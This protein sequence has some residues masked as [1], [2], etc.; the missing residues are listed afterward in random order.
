MVVAPTGFT[1]T[2]PN[3]GNGTNDSDIDPVTGMSQPFSLGSGEVR[4]EFDAGLKGRIDIA[5][6]KRVNRSIVAVGETVEFTIT[7]IN[8]G[9][10]V[11]TGVQITDPVPGGFFNISDVSNGGALNGNT[12]TWS[13][14][15][16]G[17][18][19]SITLTFS[20]V[21][22]GDNESYTNVAQVTAADQEDAD[23][24]PNNDDGDQ[25][26]D[27]EDVAS[28]VVSGCD[29]SVSVNTQ[30]AICTASNGMAQ[31][32]AT[33]GVAPF[34]YDWSTGDVTATVTNLPV[35]TVTVTIT[36]A[37]GC[38][39]TIDVEI[40]QDMSDIDVNV[41]TV[42]ITCGSVDGQAT[43]TA[44]G[45]TAPYTYAWSTGDMT[46]TVI[47]LP[48]GVFT[49]TVTDANGCVETEEVEIRFDDNNL[50]LSVV[51]TQRESCNQ[52]NDGIGEVV[53]TGG[54]QPFTYLWS[55]GFNGP[56]QT[57]LSEGV[58]TVDVI[59]G[60]R[61]TATTTVVIERAAGCGDGMTD[62]GNGTGG[63]NTGGGNNPNAI[64]LELIKRTNIS[65]PRVGDTVVFQLTV[66]NNS[67]NNATGV[68]IED[69]VPS[70]FTIVPG[71]IDNG[72]VMT[73]PNVATWTD[74]DIDAL[75]VIRLSI[76]V[77]VNESGD[78]T[79]VAQITEAD[80]IDIDSTPGN[81]DGDQ[82]EDDE[83][84]AVA[85]P[86]TTDIAITN[87]VS[88]PNPEIG[89]IV[90]YT[91]VVRNEGTVDATGVEVTDYLPVDF[92]ENFT[93]FSGNGLFLRDRIIW[94]DLFIPAGGELTLSF[95]ATV[96]PSAD[97]QVVTNFSEVTEMDQSDVDSE[98][99]NLDRTAGPREDDE[100]I[101]VFNV[102]TSSDLEL[103]KEVDQ[104]Q[105]SPNDEVQFSI[106]VTNNGPD[107][108]F[109]VGVEDI[110]PDGY[111]TIS[112]ISDDGS[113]TR[114]RLFWF[115]DE[116]AV[117]ESV[118]LTFDATVVHFTDRESDYRNVAQIVESFTFDPDSTPDNDDGDQSED[119]EDFEEVQ[120]ILDGGACVT[121]N[122]G[123]FLEG[124]YDVDAGLMTTEL[125]RLGYL[126]GQR[127]STFFGVATPAG[128][129]YNQAPWFYNGSEGAGFNQQG[130]VTNTNGNY[131]STVTDWVLV[132][133]RTD[134]S[135]ASTVCERA[136]LLHN[137][138]S[139]QFV[140]EFDCC[141]LDQSL[142]YYIVIE[143]R[144]HLL[145]MSDVPLP[146]I[147]G[148]ITYDFRAENSYR[149]VIAIGVGQKEIKRGV[150]VMFAAN[151][152]QETGVEDAVDINSN[153]LRVWLMDDGLNSSYFLRD[154]DLS[155]DVNVQDKS[156]FLSNNGNF[157]EV[158]RE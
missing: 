139:I 54:V 29:L 141:N 102:G 104:I 71:G 50:A 2:A 48:A 103:I 96:A 77:T 117:N 121:I 7:A 6:D 58:F 156:L 51:S 131:A 37:T 136:A 95:D 4:T 83:D 30:N 119:D 153:D 19:E 147:N 14:I 62:G 39:A 35:G 46:A 144:N 152:D 53:A 61:C 40:G 8:E 145:V 155:G 90:T 122:T 116:L 67:E 97:G 148:E 79:N 36:D 65:T 133:L 16:L 55:N 112:N 21:V 138:G 110:L 88:N 60:N 114:N 69:V 75:D 33:G 129:P 47:G 135:P 98:I 91:I 44:T 41:E 34:T 149:S 113:L 18:G 20:A 59:D 28:L 115:I 25:S 49:V 27:D 23:S 142:D 93:N 12:I 157:S 43:A 9:S 108:A 143:H 76:A 140:D 128:Q 3:Q 42:N 120:L 72:G 26:E 123:V 81:D 52:G 70:G 118:T 11:A 107:P 56:R 150:F 80:Q 5:L 151:G 134:V 127:P 10:S 92:C 125:N 74:L 1:F 106:T 94:S 109:G 24:T 82:S 158:R 57:G 111:G 84:S 32:N 89:D 146:V 126:P 130:P 73:S 66:F 86:E 15:E 99:A 85:Q 87:M 64:D 100:A 105:V 22:A 101:A 17:I 78:Y 63:G 154:Y 124:A 38:S 137:D 132:S 13:D 31:L 45:G 68:T